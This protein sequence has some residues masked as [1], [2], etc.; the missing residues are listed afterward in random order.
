[1]LLNFLSAM[2]P[3]LFVLKILLPPFQAGCLA[4]LY[5]DKFDSE[6]PGALQGKIE[7][8]GAVTAE[9]PTPE[10]R[11]AEEGTV[12]TNADKPA[13]EDDTTPAGAGNDSELPGPSVEQDEKGERREKD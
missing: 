2:I 6:E 12:D 5:L 10:D 11:G 1:M 4:S 8:S 7:D 9:V 13:E 3:F